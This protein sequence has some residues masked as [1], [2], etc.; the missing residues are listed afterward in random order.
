MID[1]H[2]V[3]TYD[4]RALAEGLTR[5]LEAEQHRVK[6]TVGQHAAAALETAKAERCA[7]LLIWSASAL[8]SQY[9]RVWADGIDPD[10]L[11]E[12]AAAPGALRLERRA[13]LVDFA[14][15]RGVRGARAWRQL[16]ERLQEVARVLHPPK[17]APAR[18]A[19]LAL[20]VAGVAAIGSLGISEMR[21][22]DA[23]AASQR[24]D[25]AVEPLQEP[26]A[27]TVLA[28]GGPYIPIDDDETWAAAFVAPEF[29]ELDA[30]AVTPLHDLEI[31]E[32]TELR[33][34]TLLE[35]LEALNFVRS[36]S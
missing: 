27:T 35:R 32:P 8:A 15:W 23:A 16:T 36:D 6:L 30:R 25:A 29:A 18:T 5:L 7:V 20:G 2:I 10:R 22:D 11:V 13:P 19:A 34:P 31:I 4:A 3:C 17:P 9:M 12:I 1:I 28:V 21:A 24:A 14:N 26:P 33:E